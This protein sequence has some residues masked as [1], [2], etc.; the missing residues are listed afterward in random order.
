MN[1]SLG[2]LL[3][4]VGWAA[5]AVFTASYFARRAETLRHLQMVGALLWLI[6][7]VAIS[8]PPVIVANALLLGAAAWTARRG[9]GAVAPGEAGA[10]AM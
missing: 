6:Y 8:A 9:R 5:T 3:P 10:S 4:S 7:G 1:E 2:A